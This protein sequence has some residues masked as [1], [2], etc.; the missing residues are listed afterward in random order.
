MIRI[1]PPTSKGVSY[2]TARIVAPG[3]IPRSAMLCGVN[4]PTTYGLEGRCTP[5]DKRKILTKNANK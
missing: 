1:P 2:K 3:G 4:S 5:V